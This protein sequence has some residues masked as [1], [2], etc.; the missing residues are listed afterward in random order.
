MCDA[1]TPLHVEQ[2]P[3]L[4]VCPY[5][6]KRGTMGGVLIE[7]SLLLLIVLML[8]K[9]IKS[10]FVGLIKSKLCLRALQKWYKKNA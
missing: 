5:L 9:F 8:I 10:L 2:L 3:Q 4:F 6:C 7:G 1:A